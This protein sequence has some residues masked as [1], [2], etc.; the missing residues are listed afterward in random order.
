MTREVPTLAPVVFLLYVA[1]LITAISL[2]FFRKK[3]V[4][5]T[6]AWLLI[7]AFIPWLG[8]LLYFFFGS[9][10]KLRLFSRQ[11]QPSPALAQYTESPAE[12][13]RALLTG[14]FNLNSQGR[15]GYRDL[16]LMNLRGA[17]AIYTQDNGAE[18]LR[19]GQQKY[20][21]LFDDIENA[22]ESIHVLYFILKAKDDVGRR[23]LSLLARKARQGVKVR[24][25]YDTLGCLK[26]RSADF[27]ELVEAGGMVYGYLPSLLRTLVQVNYRMHRKMVIIDGRVAYT[28]GI[29][30]GDDYLGKDPK[31]YPW[32]D[33]SIRLTGPCVREVQQRFIRDWVYLDAQSPRPYVEKIDSNEN[34]AC[35]LRQPPAAGGAGVQIVCSGPDSQYPHTKECYLRMIYHA[36]R[37]RYI[38]TPYF[39]PD[40][41]LLAALRSASRA[42]VD[43][44]LMIP[45]V[46]DKP[47][48]YHVTMWHVGELLR[49]GIRVY[50]YPGFL[51][52]KTVVLD[53]MA[54][55]VGSTNLDMR[56]F[57]LDY[58]INALVYDRAFA[59]A[60][61]WTFE[62]DQ[63]VSRQL[64]PEEYRRRPLS[65]K[66]KESVLR[67]VTPLM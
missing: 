49:C 30:I 43:V 18:L 38:Q 26:T 23:F 57:D 25:I 36:K 45:G 4:G 34:L 56:S 59:M 5:S 58:E 64:T 35:L 31:I 20:G 61:R 22:Q 28:G 8:F 14:R 39:I 27:D 65:D 41:T 63:A 51:H 12:N 16:I 13:N 44:R 2:L 46:P 37:Y 24:L 47:Y 66:I 67:L 50:R 9:T 19:D 62:Q 33:T 7:F 3:Q 52:A 15:E 42:G 40:E 55:S 21:R 6:L 1:N 10:Q 29:N 11:Y 60:C 32:R 53:D 54:A 48:A 17:S